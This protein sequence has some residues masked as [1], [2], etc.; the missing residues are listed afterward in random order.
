MDKLLYLPSII[1]FLIIIILIIS[2]R[3]TILHTNM[4]NQ[5]V[6]HEVIDDFLNNDSASGK[7][8]VKLIRSGLLRT[9]K[10]GNHGSLFP[11]KK[12]L[13]IFKKYSTKKISEALDDISEGL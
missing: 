9:M 1:V 12:Q 3:L 5:N 11:E 2:D 6:M 13:S 4:K 7:A 8:F 10:G